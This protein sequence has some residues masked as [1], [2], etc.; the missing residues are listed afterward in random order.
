MF[1]LLNTLVWL[2]NIP[3]MLYLPLHNGKQILP[4]CDDTIYF[5]DIYNLYIVVI[6]IVEIK[7]LSRNNGKSQE[8][9]WSRIL[10]LL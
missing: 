7:Y 6:S 8:K 10:H 5:W 2:R 4:V 9:T 1:H 3:N